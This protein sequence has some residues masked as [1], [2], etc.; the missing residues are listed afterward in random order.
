LCALSISSSALA[1]AHH[2]SV[3]RD[4]IKALTLWCHALP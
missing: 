4:S 3:A 2:M 1:N